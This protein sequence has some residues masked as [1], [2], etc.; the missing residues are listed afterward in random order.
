MSGAHLVSAG[1]GRLILLLLPVLR[2]SAWASICVCICSTGDVCS[3]TMP[4]GRSKRIRLEDDPTEA[5]PS[6]RNPAQHFETAQQPDQNDSAGPAPWLPGLVGAEPDSDGEVESASSEEEDT[7]KDGRKRW[8]VR[9]KAWLVE[10][11]RR[12]QAASS[13]RLGPS[14]PA[15]VSKRRPGSRIKDLK[16]FEPHPKLERLFTG[17]G[18]V[19][20]AQSQ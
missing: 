7:S 3:S 11:E 1:L 20:H 17:A 15:N 6:V 19:V 8:R 16:E 4:S 13:E 10:Y 9:R 12:V 2:P 18:Q 14:R 5:T